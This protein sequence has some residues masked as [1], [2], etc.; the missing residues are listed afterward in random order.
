MSGFSLASARVA[1]SDGMAP[2][3]RFATPMF[4]SLRSAT[5]LM[6]LCLGNHDLVDV[7]AV[8]EVDGR[9]RQVRVLGL[10]QDQNVHADIAHLDLA[11]RDE[12]Q[13]RRRPRRRAELDLDALLLVEAERIAEEQEAMIGLDGRR[14][15][16]EL[17]LRRL[18]IHWSCGQA[19][20]QYERARGAPKFNC[21]SSV[22]LLLGPHWVALVVFASHRRQ[23]LWGHSSH[24]A[25]RFAQGSAKRGIT[26]SPISSIERM[27]RVVR[28]VARLKHEDHLVETR[29]RPIARLGGTPFRGRRRSPSRP[30]SARRWS[31]WRSCR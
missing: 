17:Y 11:G 7:A 5:V 14:G 1:R 2:D 29:P 21:V 9:D 23:R 31:G 6:S 10:R 18:R 8:L 25:L 15:A 19:P 16:P 22:G 13:R 20:R 12:L 27:H 3:A 26:F 4:L 28:G 30:R 24:L